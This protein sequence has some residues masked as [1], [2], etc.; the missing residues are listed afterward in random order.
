MVKS[1]YQHAISL[2]ESEEKEVEELLKQ[3]SFIAIL[4]AGIEAL[5]E[6]K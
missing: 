4:R 6:K 3:H 1:R 2:S 5:K